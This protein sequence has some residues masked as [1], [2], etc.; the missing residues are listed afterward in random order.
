MTVEIPETVKEALHHLSS[1]EIYVCGG[2]IRDALLGRPFKDL[3]LTVPGGAH[4][5]ARQIAQKF[6][7]HLV[8]LDEK[9]EV[10]RV[11]IGDFFLDFSRFR[12][13]TRSIVEDLKERDFT[14]NALALPLKDFLDLPPQKWSLI[15][16]LGGQKDLER[17]LVKAI[18]RENLLDD[19]LRMLRGYRLAA[20]LSFSLEA[21]TRGWVQ[22]L[23]FEIQKVSPERIVSELKALLAVKAGRIISLMAEDEI[24]FAIFPELER[25]RGVAQPSFHHLD[26]LGHLLLSLEMEDLVIEDPGRYFGRWEEGNPFSSISFDPEKQII[27]RLAAL[28]HDIGKPETFAIRHRI[29]FYEHDRVGAQIFVKL[30]ERLRFP[31]KLAR[32]TAHLIR[33]HMRPFHLLG[34]YRKGRLTKRAMRRLIKDVPRYEMLFMVAM[35]DSL[36][37]AGPD[38]EPG[39]ERE[40]ADLFREIHRFYRETLVVQEKERLVTGR[41]LI[42][43][44]GLEPGPLF[45]ELLEAVEEARAEGKLKTR[46]EALQFLSSLISKRFQQG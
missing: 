36:A 9:E 5:L 38:K 16:P 2:A 45:R 7:A 46:E 12:K 35:A 20:E 11:V 3:D 25:A 42:D 18:G 40:L 13:E 24:L 43:L 30:A 31:K 32:E 23:A 28:F 17:R 44:F 10:F 6:A 1:R 21:R 34:E 37:S 41:D 19:P 14:I 15:D 8:A 39:L 27:L 22:E 4:K 26:V 29:T 33:H